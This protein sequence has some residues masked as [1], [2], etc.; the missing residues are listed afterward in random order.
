MS[1]TWVGIDVSKQWLD[2][3]VRPTGEHWRSEQTLTG[4]TSLVERL[5]T[6]AP[7]LVVVEPTGGLE[8]AVVA[9]LAAAGVAVAVVNA[10]QVRDFAKATGRLAKTDALDAQVL[11][12]FAEA[13]RPR[14]RPLPT[15]EQQVVAALVARRTQ[16]VE[17]HTAAGN[18]RASA[19]PA[20]HARLDAHLAWLA[21]ELTSLD[22]EL[23][24]ALQASPLWQERD[25]LLQSVPGVGPVTA[26]TLLAALPELGR[27][28]PKPLAALVGVAPL[29]CDSG[30]VR[31]RRVVWGG[32][33]RVRTVLYMAA[34]VASRW[35]PVIR[36]FYQRLLAAGKPKKVA[37]VACMHTLLTV[38]SALLHQ[39]TPWRTA[40][41]D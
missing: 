17:M 1:E 19:P 30:R 6:V 2:I 32:R 29:N 12:H 35:N 33:A 23:D 11:A 31:G 4:I 26:R 36:A 16:L 24:Q 27:L 7:T 15:A 41:A 18:R 13:V 9:A 28:E 25:R 39:H 20:L 38:L 8:R 3:A 37:L 22:D 14:P 21:A 10:R 34:L 40:A 5:A